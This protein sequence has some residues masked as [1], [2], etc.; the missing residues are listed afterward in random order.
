MDKS[1]RNKRSATNNKEW[2]TVKCDR[3][4]LWFWTVPCQ[5]VWFYLIQPDASIRYHPH[6]SVKLWQSPQDD[7]WQH[8]VSSWIYCQIIHSQQFISL[9][10][11]NQW[12]K[13]SARLEIPVSCLTFSAPAAPLSLTFDKQ[14]RCRV[15]SVQPTLVLWHWLQHWHCHKSILWAIDWNAQTSKTYVEQLHSFLWQF[16]MQ[17][18]RSQMW[19]IPLC[20]RVLHT[21]WLA[22]HW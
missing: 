11:G 17:Q 9:M 20:F 5:N 4:Y 1:W 8:H 22:I 7:P 18:T 21:T 3:E 14:S 15:S 10:G 2:C 6:F 19:M 16:L 13:T 12:V